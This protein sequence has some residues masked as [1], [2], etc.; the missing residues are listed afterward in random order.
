MY[1]TKY[2][3]KTALSVA[4]FSLVSMAMAQKGT[5]VL[6]GRVVDTEGNPI[7]GAVVSVAEQSRIAVTDADGNF[8]LKGVKVADE[9]NVSSVGYF[10]GVG[11]AVLDGTFTV[12]LEPDVDKYSHDVPLPF[13]NR[14]SKLSTAATSVV[15]GETLQKYPITILQNAFTSTLNGVETYEWS[16]EPGWSETQS[17]IR[18]IRSMNTSARSPLII[19]DNVERDLSFLDAYPI[20]SITILKDA[21]AAAIYGMRGA[22]GVI[23]V[24]TKRGA[25]GKTHIEFTQEI[26]WQKLSDKMELQ[27]SYNQ[28]LTRNRVRYL[29][30]MS[31]LYSDYDIEMYRRVC[32][33]EQLEG[34]EQYKY[35]NTN[36]FDVL[37]RENAPQTKTNFQIS[38]GNNR[39]R[40]Y[41]SFSWLH[42]GGM[43]N[44]D[45]NNTNWVDSGQAELDRYNLRSNIDIDINKYLNVQ[46]DLGGRIDNISQPDISVFNLTTFGAV[47]ATPFEPVFTP[48]GEV[49]GS[50]TATNPMAQLSTGYNK[51]RR[52]NMYSTL[53]VNADLEKVLPGLKAFGTVSFD[54]FE[55][56]QRVMYTGI[57]TYTYGYASFNEADYQNVLNGTYG[58]NGEYTR[59]WTQVQ[60]DPTFSQREFY[61]NINMNGGLGY[62]KAFGKH[63]IDARAFAR[64]YRQEVQGSNSSVRQ[65]SFNGQ[66]NY[67]FDKRYILN[68][69]YSYMGSD[70]F[71]PDERWGHFWG[72]SAAWNIAEEHFI[73][74][75][76]DWLDLAKVRVSYGRAGQSATGA[77]RYPYQSTYGSTTGY[78]FGYSQSYTTG[79]YESLAGNSNNKWEISDMFNVGFD[80]D[81][82]KSKL[83]GS[84]DYF[85]EWRSNILVNRSTIPDMVGVSVAQDSYGK[86]ETW[87][88]E[89]KLGH[90]SQIGKDFTYHIE[91]N[92]TFNDNKITEMDE[93]EPS[94]EWQRKTGWRIVDET[95]VVGLYESAFNGGIGGWKR[96][97][98]QQ[99]ASDPNLIATSQ[100]DAIANPEKY[101][102]NTAS[103][104]K[105]ALGT[106]VFVDRNG[107]R[108]IDTNDMA[109]DSYT[110][111]PQWIINL[112]F[113]FEWKGFDASATL[114]A[115]LNRDVF[116]SP[117]SVFSGWSNMSTHLATDMWGYYTDDPTDPRN[118]GAKFPRPV[119]GD[120]NK[121]DSERGTDAYM[122]DVW[123]MDGDYLSLKQIEVGYSL[124][125][126]W[127]KKIWMTKC[128]VYFNAYNVCNWSGLPNGM[129]PEKPMSYCWWYPKTRSFNFGIN[130]GF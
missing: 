70:N 107:D 85:Y 19:V 29:S 42:Q 63:E 100:A 25:A 26:G 8:S 20:E 103:Q 87:G 43:W 84:F 101:P 34:Y 83:Y 3:A 45:S 90:R 28:A 77:G 91:A 116:I 123:I 41:V 114:T 89:A 59:F 11:E 33:G 124:P 36:W 18:G 117:A 120:F 98:F 60:N 30:G 16:A 115:N 61:Y 97:K 111:I 17:Y 39:A 88:F 113:G 125:Q 53:S 66:L 4:F 24:T 127:I 81:V 93:A 2:I 15:T 109:Y 68:G 96:Y 9:I 72:A 52:R 67:A 112:N 38:G 22:N 32:N 105:Q 65:L 21:A 110:I 10:N 104:G 49:Y 73:K 121:I 122:N 78:N 76:S 62:E 119:W 69:N 108:Q 82:A 55:T 74:D 44:E 54:S 130:I 12:T 31:P 13:H 57:A 95:S 71:D 128:R 51:N 64:F 47:E 40:Y 86:A 75:N 99:W 27:N 79:F 102:Y 1:N 48:T 80:F 7:P 58:N 23:M 6:T 94:V 46:L 126:N 118:V 14:E 106:A 37:Y 92:A 129:D 50:S 56:F 35:F 5:Q